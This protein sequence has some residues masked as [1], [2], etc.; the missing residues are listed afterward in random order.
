LI[1]PQ[2]IAPDD[3]NNN[4]YPNKKSIALEL[5]LDAQGDGEG[6]SQVAIPFTDSVLA[7][8]WGQALQKLIDTSAETAATLP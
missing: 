2:G 5:T 8:R 3:L 4:P 6:R 1:D 7:I